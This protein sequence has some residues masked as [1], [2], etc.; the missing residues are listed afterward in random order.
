MQK[1][2][3]FAAMMAKVLRNILDVPDE[4][5]YRRIK[6]TANSVS[7][8]AWRMR[9]STSVSRCAIRSTSQMAGV[10][11]LIQASDS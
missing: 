6:V 3:E 8:S 2:P 5:K 9:V 11:R 7:D 1:V 4:T 10:E